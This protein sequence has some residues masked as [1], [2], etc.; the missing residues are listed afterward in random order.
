MNVGWC[1][2]QK[3]FKVFNK[4]SLKFVFGFLGIIIIAMI[5][6][7][8][9]CYFDGKTDDESLPEMNLADKVALN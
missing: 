2:M 6:L 7:V 3:V 8:I 9:I 5:V 1:I 4:V